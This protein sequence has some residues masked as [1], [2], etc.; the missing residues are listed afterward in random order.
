[1]KHMQSCIFKR[2]QAL[3][4]FAGYPA[5][6]ELDSYVVMSP[7]GEAAPSQGY[8]VRP[9]RNNNTGFFTTGVASDM[10]LGS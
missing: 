2:M 5:G 4:L 1:M 7:A 8:S 10:F 9:L 6:F 3:F